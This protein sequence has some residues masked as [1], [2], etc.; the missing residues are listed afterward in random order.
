MTATPTTRTGQIPRF[1]EASSSCL[2][3]PHG[4]RPS[5]QPV[6]RKL[7]SG[8]TSLGTCRITCF[9]S[10]CTATT[11]PPSWTAGETAGTTGS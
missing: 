7:G 3:P 8:T 10:R 1:R 6:T 9:G 5:E 11:T 4:F 2:L